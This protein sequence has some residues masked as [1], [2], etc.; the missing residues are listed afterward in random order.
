MWHMN[1]IAGGKHNAR[2]QDVCFST[3]MSRSFA[4]HQGVRIWSC[5]SFISSLST[6][7]T[8]WATLWPSSTES[9]ANL[10]RAI[11]SSNN[12]DPPFPTPCS[13][14]F[15]NSVINASLTFALHLH[16]SPLWYCWTWARLSSSCALLSSCSFLQ[17]YP[18]HRTT[19]LSL[20]TNFVDSI[21]FLAWVVSISHWFNLSTPMKCHAM[22]PAEARPMCQNLFCGPSERLTLQT[23]SLIESILVSCVILWK[24]RMTQLRN[25]APSTLGWFGLV[26]IAYCFPRKANP[27]VLILPVVQE[28]RPSCCTSLLSVIADIKRSNMVVLL[29]SI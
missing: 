1:H 22:L 23:P 27:V 13:C 5:P 11:H 9:V 15:L 20:S 17:Q 14:A 12:E 16:C 4:W 29:S 8:T 28:Q 6:A 3:W 2:Q 7:W 18:I 10:L 19:A 26:K 25:T 21:H 24:E